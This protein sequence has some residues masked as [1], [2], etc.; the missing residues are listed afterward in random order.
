MR[1]DR[2]L[3]LSPQSFDLSPE[4]CGL[5]GALAVG[6]YSDVPT[7]FTHAAVGYAAARAAGGRRPFPARILIAATLLPVVPDLDV[8]LRPWFRYG[9]PL[10][11]RG[12]SH[13]LAFALFLGVLAALA[14]RQDAARVPGGIG[15]LALLFTTIAAS[16]GILDALTD[17]GMGIPFLMP[18][19]NSRYFFPV[20]P[21]PVSPIRVSSLLS[22]WGLEVLRG[23]LLLIWPFAAAAVVWARGRGRA[24]AAVVLLLAAVGAAA[25]GQ[26]LGAFAAYAG[27][28]TSWWW[29][30]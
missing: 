4:L 26:R 16:H 25:W 9:H 28:G 22:D 6:H 14:C 8:L 19:D 24:R 18:F 27:P 17:G 11:H 1:P 20:R 29:G 30:G 5:D 3:G 21:I 2:S 12:I 15:G 23:E 13:S 7:V 10:G